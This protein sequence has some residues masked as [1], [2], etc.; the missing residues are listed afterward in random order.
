MFYFMGQGTVT[1]ANNEIAS[2]W[3]D[4]IVYSGYVGDP[5]IW[6]NNVLQPS[7]TALSA[8]VVSGNNL[9]TQPQ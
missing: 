8:P 1:F 9:V 7:G 4:G 6:A 3:H 5:I 2:G